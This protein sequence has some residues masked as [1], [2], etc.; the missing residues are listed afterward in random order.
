[1]SGITYGTV[2]LI[3]WATFLLV[4]IVS[5][6]SVK[7]DI[8]GSGI[9]GVW[10]R[11]FLLRFV[12]I[13]VLAL[14]GARLATGAAHIARI[15]T[16]IFNNGVFLPPLALAWFGALLAVIGVLF[17]IWARAHLG[18]NWS[19]APAIK[20]E[21]ELVTSGPYRFVRHPIY[22]GVILAAFGT[23]LT[24]SIFGAGMFIAS[25]IMFVLRIAKEERIMLQLFPNTYPRYQ[26]RTKKLIPFIW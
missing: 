11:Y 5:A 12:A 26:A 4:W 2:I 14:A 7:R 21:H 18:R 10:Y 15:D 23:A 3:C 13:V 8:R 25:G 24:G 1:M 20:E 16:A 22:T 17:A 19:P 9:G 6:F